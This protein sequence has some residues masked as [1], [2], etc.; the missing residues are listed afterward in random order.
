M[1]I[2]SH[3]TPPPP[4]IVGSTG[5]PTAPVPSASRDAGNEAVDNMGKVEA[6]AVL[7]IIYQ[8]YSD[9]VAKGTL[10]IRNSGWLLPVD[11]SPCPHER[12]ID[13]ETEYRELRRRRLA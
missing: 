10:S 5:T 3:L 8:R 1:L 9:D 7:V 6:A 2:G 13:L 11:G 12:E 4:S